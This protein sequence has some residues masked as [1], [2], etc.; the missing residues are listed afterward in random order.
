MENRSACTATTIPKP[1]IV[2][3]ARIR[4][5]MHT[6]TRTCKNLRPDDFLRPI[7]LR[8]YVLTKSK[9]SFQASSASQLRPI[10]WLPRYP[11]RANTRHVLQRC[12]LTWSAHRQGH[13]PCPAH[14]KSRKSELRKIRTPCPASQKSHF[15][16]Q[17]LG[18]LRAAI[19]FATSA[20][21]VTSIQ[22]LLQARPVGLVVCFHRQV[23][24]L[25]LILWMF[26]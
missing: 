7:R 16:F 8:P 6:C 9:N 21:V 2:F 5:I 13:F 4:L 3:T 23:G 25:E 17:S 10:S 20:L 11:L 14:S 12:R 1:N 26:F 18:R 19:V 15:M 22:L 24:T